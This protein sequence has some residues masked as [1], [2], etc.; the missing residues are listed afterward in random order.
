MTDVT[1]TRARADGYMSGMQGVYLVAAELSRLGFIVSPTSRSARGADLLVTDQ[2]CERA[3]SVQV[4]TN[5]RPTSFWL[6]GRHAKDLRSP[7]HAYVFV[8]LRGIERPEFLVASAAH[9]ADHTRVEVR[10]RSTWYAFYKA[11]RPSAG[12]GWELFGDAHIAA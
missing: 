2:S 5:R 11:N 12:E 9:V 7:S 1:E 6:T 8:N 10:E 4:K 3:W